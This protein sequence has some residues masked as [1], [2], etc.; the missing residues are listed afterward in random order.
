MGLPA[1]GVTRPFL[2]VGDVGYGCF[3]VLIQQQN[4]QVC[5]QVQGP[6]SP[7]QWMLW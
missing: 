2:H 3:G 4:G 6:S 1:E 5:R 7:F